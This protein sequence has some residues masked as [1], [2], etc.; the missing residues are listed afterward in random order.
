MF[1]NEKRE[2]STYQI[3]FTGI[4][5]VILGKKNMD[6][7]QGVDRCTSFEEEDA[8]GKIKKVRVIV[9]FFPVRENF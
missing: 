2:N 3:P 9:N 5:F 4:S 1:Q 7:T 6:C 8:G